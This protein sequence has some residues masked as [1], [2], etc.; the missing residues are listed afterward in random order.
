MI[1]YYVCE[2][3]DLNFGSDRTAMETHWH[4]VHQL[5]F[6]TDRQIAALDK[7]TK[8]IKELLRWLRAQR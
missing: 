7:N 2:L 8:V 4:N 3:C 6:E 5:K 1:T